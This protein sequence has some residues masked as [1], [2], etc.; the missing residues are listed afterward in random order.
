MYHFLEVKDELHYSEQHVIKYCLDQP[1]WGAMVANQG[2]GPA[3]VPFKRLTA[4]K[5]ADAIRLA[6][7]EPMKSKAQILGTKMRLENGVTAG[8]RSF[9]RHLPLTSMRC[10]FD[11]RA[12]AT[13]YDPVRHVKLSA[14]VAEVLIEHGRIGREELGA[15]RPKYWDLKKVPHEDEVQFMHP[16]VEGIDGE[17]EEGVSGIEGT[18]CETSYLKRRRKKEDEKEEG[19][20]PPV[21]G[22]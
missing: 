1:F 10:D 19:I 3:P 20:L 2:V 7:S 12:I 22:E 13:L 9:H 4:D 8:V 17:T 6:I 15:Y 5:L 18:F 16:R 21:K 14:A 11:P